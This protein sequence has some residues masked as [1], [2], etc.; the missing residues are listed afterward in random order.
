MRI[1]AQPTKCLIETAQQHSQRRLS[2][3]TMQC[4]VS[5]DGA[6]S[7]QL[8][9]A[10][11]WSCEQ[12]LLFF[13]H[14]GPCFHVIS[15]IMQQA[16]LPAHPCCTPALRR[17]RSRT[18]APTCPRRR[19]RSAPWPGSSWRSPPSRGT[20]WLFTC[21]SRSPSQKRTCSGAARVLPAVSQG[22]DGHFTCEL[23]IIHMSGHH[24]VAINFS[25]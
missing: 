22:R 15:Q 24:R 5:P 6:G 13:A 19:P 2:E 23:P 16:A 21:S 3:R 12:I 25:G 4:R 1:L 18:S 9:E 10:P 11:D 20:P 14:Q 8:H 7:L 17:C